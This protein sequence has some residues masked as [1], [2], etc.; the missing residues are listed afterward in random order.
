MTF[1]EDISWMYGMHTAI[2]VGNMSKY[3]PLLIEKFH[4]KG[5]LCILPTT[6][7]NY[8]SRVPCWC[9]RCDLLKS[10]VVDREPK[11]GIKVGR[12]EL[13]TYF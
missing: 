4:Y 6:K 10:L 9:S 13:I 2:N 12:D 7:R 8:C 11:V 3:S 1:G 5:S